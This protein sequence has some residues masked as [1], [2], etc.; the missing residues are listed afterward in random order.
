M[1]VILLLLGR[2]TSAHIPY[3][4]NSVHFHSGA[5]DFGLPP[6]RAVLSWRGEHDDRPQ[7]EDAY[8]Y[9]DRI[10]LELTEEQDDLRTTEIER[11]R[12][13]MLRRF[14]AEV[15][16]QHWKAAQLLL[17]RFGNR[18]GWQGSLR[19]R[20]QVM[21]RIQAQRSPLSPA[22][23]D[24]L[25]L[26]L[27]R[28]A[29][30]EVRK[31][32]PADSAFVR[33]SSDPNAGFL[34]EHALYQQA[35]LEAKFRYRH[36]A[37][38][39]FL[40][41]LQQYPHTTKR[42]DALVMIARCSL[43]PKTESE[44]RLEDGRSALAQLQREF[45]YTRFRRDIVGL[46]GRLYFLAQRWPDALRCY[47]MN[48][49]LPSVEMVLKAMPIEQ[50]GPVRV[51][52]LSAYLRDLLVVR[53]WYDFQ[54]SLVGADRTRFAMTAP[55]VVQFGQLL[56]QE[57]DTAAAYLYYRLYHTEM[58]AKDLRS[59]T[60]LAERLV[61]RYPPAQLPA[62]LKVR[63]AE[64]Y[65]R[66]GRYHQ[67]LDWANRAMR[68]AISDRALFVRAAAENRLGES[69]AALADFQQ[70]TRHFPGSPL[71]H[72]AW[73]NLALLYEARHDY[74][75][76]LDR[77]FALDYDEDIAYLLD[78]RMTPTQIAEYLRR[79]TASPHRNLVAYSLGIRYLRE[80][81]WTEARRML[82][83][84]P[85]KVY[86]KF[87]DHVSDYW[88]ETHKIDPLQALSDL[89]RLQRAVA[90]A[91]T[92][93]TK[94]SALYRYAAYFNSHDELLLYNGAL[95]K[96]DR[97]IDFQ[98]CWNEKLEKPADR[99]AI[100]AHIYAHEIY[101]RSH[102]LCM[103][104]VHRYPHSPTVPY[105]LMLAA[106]DALHLSRFN[107]L[108]D[109]ENKHHDYWAEMHRLKA[110]LVRDYPRHH[111]AEKIHLNARLFPEDKNLYW[112]PERVSQRTSVTDR[113][114]DRE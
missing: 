91:G 16:A 83:S 84:V 111:L 19:D 109:E 14:D 6:R 21:Q 96:G 20:D 28:L 1:M 81:R 102:T 52:L 78:I 107:S 110:R 30:D 61:A 47:F 57:P 72:A 89:E 112:R 8:G 4:Y 24:V 58:T 88:G 90:H 40:Q 18:Y 45:P 70:L 56:L 94:A 71:V 64:I 103:E 2:Y 23:L 35:C 62:A 36:R 80:E 22:F 60:R 54:Q 17:E 43:L 42:E 11:K 105:A 59:L 101:A 76:A 15:A 93:N 99:R 114:A 100:R 87:A 106:I 69:D 67:T 55:Q 77:Y 50:R 79:H 31:D 66:D 51:R 37:V 9:S 74:D 108:W 41:L 27:S 46:N 3:V 13:L 10:G 32:R 113:V 63:L 5:P 44:R 48:R 29:I 39:L 65:Y 34:R 75:S 82:K 95:W 26:Y 12:K 68:P 97:A 104:I 86:H 73:E 7:S 38:D 33:L 25:H 98:F 92:S 49:D 85:D 53:R